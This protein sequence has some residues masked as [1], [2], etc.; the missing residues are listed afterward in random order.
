MESLVAY[1]NKKNFSINL[2][3]KSNK[4]FIDTYHHKEKKLS[5]RD[6]FTLSKITE[7]SKEYFLKKF[8]FI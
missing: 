1:N 6:S 3:N 2:E 4:Y 8:I 7:K 5:M